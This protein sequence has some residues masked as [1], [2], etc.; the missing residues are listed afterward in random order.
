MS[1]YDPNQGWNT[2]QYPTGNY[3]QSQTPIHSDRPNFQ[4]LIG[5]ALVGVLIL[6]ALYNLVSDCVPFPVT[7]AQF[8]A[9]SSG[10]QNRAFSIAA[11]VDWPQLETN[12]ANIVRDTVPLTR[13]VPVPG[14]TSKYQAAVD[15]QL[16]TGQ[17][18]SADCSDSSD[19]QEQGE[20]AALSLGTPD[21]IYASSSLVGP[22]DAPS[23]AQ[24]AVTTGNGQIKTQIPSLATLQAE[25]KND[26][27]QDY[28]NYN[29]LPMQPFTSSFGSGYYS[30]FTAVT[31]SR[32]HPA[33][34]HGYR[35]TILNG[36][37]VIQVIE[38]CDSWHW[39]ARRGMFMHVLKSVDYGIA[40]Q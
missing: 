25:W 8:N 2:G 34:V 23:T 40:T 29:E 16:S 22:S 4:A 13:I 38:Q 12:P 10:C 28:S 1:Q 39:L 11:P 32:S 35:A 9:D 7:Y 33:S 36:D 5:Y 37:E 20:F 30:E 24:E 27:T 3:P 26:T 18:D 6:T 17:S 21:H 14:F 19:S 15:S 31:R